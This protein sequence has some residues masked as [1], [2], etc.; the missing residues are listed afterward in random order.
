M[1]DPAPGQ[2]A[3]GWGVTQAPACL[4]GYGPVGGQE[5][6][7][8]TQVTLAHDFRLRRTKFP[9]EAVTL[10]VGP[11]FPPGPGHPSHGYVL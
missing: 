1:P 4:T 3:V 8:I 5:Q 2:R 6:S 7:V 9:F 10:D 11:A